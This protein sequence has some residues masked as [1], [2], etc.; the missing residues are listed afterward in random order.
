MVFLEMSFGILEMS[1]AY[2]P[3]MSFGQNGQKKACTMCRSEERGPTD[4]DDGLQADM[5][6]NP[7]WSGM[8]TDILGAPWSMIYV[9]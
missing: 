8:S 2:F 3:E 1:F 5:G 6:P 7:N 4:H 9:E